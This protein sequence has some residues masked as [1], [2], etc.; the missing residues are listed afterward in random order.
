MSYIPVEDRL[1]IGEMVKYYRTQ[2]DL[3]QK[4]L[5]KKMLTKKQQR[6]LGLQQ[7]ALGSCLIFENGLYKCQVGSFAKK[8]NAQ[9]LLKRYYININHMERYLRLNLLKI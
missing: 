9:K 4:E 6:E 3:T 7:N 2:Q 8:E 1:K 5:A